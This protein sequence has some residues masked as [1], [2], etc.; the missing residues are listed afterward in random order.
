[1][2][3]SNIILILGSVVVVFFAYKWYKSGDPTYEPLVTLLSSL[4]TAIA[5]YFAWQNDGDTSHKIDVRGNN[6]I[7]VGGVSNSEINITKGEKEEDKK[8]KKPNKKR[9]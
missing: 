8:P 9:P 4:V 7:V 2:K 6:H 5:Y 3:L 1:M